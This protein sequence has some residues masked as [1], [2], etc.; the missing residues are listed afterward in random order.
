MRLMAWKIRYIMYGE[1][2]DADYQ[3]KVLKTD[4]GQLQKLIFNRW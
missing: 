1:W 4:V 2:T 3:I